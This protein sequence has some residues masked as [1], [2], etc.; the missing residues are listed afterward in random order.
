MIWLVILFS[1]S[2]GGKD[3]KPAGKPQA[4]QKQGTQPG[5]GRWVILAQEK[6]EP[7]AVVIKTIGT[8]PAFLNYRGSL[9]TS[10]LHADSVSVSSLAQSHTPRRNQCRPPLPPQRKGLALREFLIE[11]VGVITG[12]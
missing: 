7:I 1:H 9:V 11:G 5:P 3:K 4:S 12:N 8:S 2:W 10:Y 6:K